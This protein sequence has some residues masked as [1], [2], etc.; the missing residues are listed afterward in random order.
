L[1]SRTYTIGRHGDI[2]LNDDTVGR[3]HAELIV[4]DDN[5]YLADLDSVNGIEQIK[6]GLRVPFQKG[7]VTPDDEFAFGECIKSIQELLNMLAPAA[8]GSQG[9]GQQGMPKISAA[10]AGHA[11]TASKKTTERSG[12]RVR[13]PGCGAVVLS[14]NEKCPECG[15]GL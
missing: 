11:K 15:E 4:T 2:K 9:K 10:G 8:G 14:Y 1:K 6:D 5:Y 3:R 12:Q 7:Y 13:C